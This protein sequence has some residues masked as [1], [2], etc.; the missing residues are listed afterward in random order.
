MVNILVSRFLKIQRY[1][2]RHLNLLMKK[3]S[4]FS[5]IFFFIFAL[6]LAP[7]AFSNA[8]IFHDCPPGGSLKTKDDHEV[9]KLKNRIDIPKGFEDM[10][11]D[12]L[13]RLPIPPGVSPKRRFGWPFDDLVQV[14]AQEKRAVR[15]EGYIVAT[16]QAHAE[17]CNCYSKTD[18]DFHIWLAGSPNDSKAN[19]VVTEATPRI[20][21]NHPS[22]TLD[23]LNKFVENHTKV[24]ISGWIML[25]ADCPECVGKTRGTLWE[26][27]PVLKI[28]AQEAEGW[29]EL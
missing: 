2:A 29:R 20:K 12:T 26:I 22:W 19:A 10:S 7:S 25:D 11:F 21:L 3:I 6:F 24:R 4:P 1:H 15:V 8:N 14:Q 18:L 9:N 27:H 17:S 28:E 23:N 16:N 5:L 13:L